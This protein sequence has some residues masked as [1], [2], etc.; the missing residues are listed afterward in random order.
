MYAART[1]V[2]PRQSTA[3]AFPDSPLQTADHDSWPPAPLPGAHLL[4]LPGLRPVLIQ[5][6]R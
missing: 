4:D 5:R 1:L 6:H 2:N 3:I